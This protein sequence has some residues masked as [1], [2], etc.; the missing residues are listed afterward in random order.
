MPKWQCM[1]CMRDNF[2]TEGGLRQHLRTHSVCSQ[3][4]NISAID[5]S[6]NVSK[7]C[8][9]KSKKK[10]TK[11]VQDEVDNFSKLPTKRARLPRQ[12]VSNS[13]QNPKGGQLLTTAMQVQMDAHQKSSEAVANDDSSFGQMDH[14]EEGTLETSERRSMANP[15]CDLQIW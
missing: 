12:F 3:L 2:K 7:R 9:N 11:H 14:N 6:K 10:G 13:K 4:D 8:A 5:V 15:I 1:H